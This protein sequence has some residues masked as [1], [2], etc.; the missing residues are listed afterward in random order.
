MNLGTA[1]KSVIST[2]APLIGTALGGPLGNAA[3]MFVEKALGITPTDDPNAL[4]AAVAGASPDTLLKLKQ[5]N[6]DFQAHM[7]EL[8]VQEEQ[9]AYADTDSARKREV[10]V[11]DRTPAV[12]AFLITAGFF[13]VLGFLLVVGKPVN[14]DAILVMLGSLG[15][16]WAG[17]VTYYY[18][19]SAGSESKSQM[20]NKLAGSAAVA[21]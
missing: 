4:D 6:F 10:A 15:T 8:G 19:S 2:V 9:L 5:A 13:G 18:G 14:G 21:K 11:K 17:V 20:L 3:V 1:A 7:K 12:L 16:A